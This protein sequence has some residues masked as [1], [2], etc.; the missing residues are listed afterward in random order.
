MTDSTGRYR[1][2]HVFAGDVVVQADGG[3]DGRAE[4]AVE[5]TVGQTRRVDLKLSQGA[6][7]SGRVVDVSGAPL[8]GWIVHARWTARGFEEVEYEKWGGWADQVRTD[9]TGAFELIRC[10]PS[11]LGV[12]VFPPQGISGLPA[13]SFDVDRAPQSDLTLVVDTASEADAWISGHVRMDDG[14]SLPSLR[15]W[16]SQPGTPNSRAAMGSL[17]PE[18]G[19]FRIGPLRAGT[20]HLSIDSDS[21]P[22]FRSRPI[23]LEPEE[24]RVLQP[25]ELTPAG[26]LAV[27]VERS[28]E[29]TWATVTIGL[30]EEETHTL[31]LHFIPGTSW[32]SSPL[33]PGPLRVEV[34]IPGQP[35]LE[36][37]V[38]IRSREETELVI[39]V[40]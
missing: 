17:D 36:R 10:P 26:W 28:G 34:R 29:R 21:A 9:A 15:I 22:S 25:I 13:A 6:V 11:E 14:T 37:R 23:H 12:G 5:L 8:S 31:L 2:E 38:E 35:T 20:W 32:R 1:L 27:R 19:G 7:V 40:D 4:H 33:E 30:Y 18:S 39:E 16:A 24:Q 3:R